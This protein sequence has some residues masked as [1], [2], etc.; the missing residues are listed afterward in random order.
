MTIS[1]YTETSN[2]LF[3]DSDTPSACGGVVHFFLCQLKG[4][5]VG[6]IGLGANNREIA[7][8][9]YISERT[10]KNHVTSILSRLNLRDRTQAALF[11][12]S[13]LPQQRQSDDRR[14]HE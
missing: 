2:L 4:R 1:S 5:N 7:A 11:A 8:S 3:F 13:V 12:N 6:L 10:V 14:A 9:L